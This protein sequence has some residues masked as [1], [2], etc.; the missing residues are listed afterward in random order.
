M[1][2]LWFEWWLAVNA[3]FAPPDPEDWAAL[4]PDDIR[5]IQE[6]QQVWEKP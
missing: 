4:T 6:L 1:P 3:I 2:L 5:R